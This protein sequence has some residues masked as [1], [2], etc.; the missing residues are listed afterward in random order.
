MRLVN[1]RVVAY[2]SALLIIF[3]MVAAPLAQAVA[4]GAS[5]AGCDHAG[6]IHPWHPDDGCAGGNDASH[7]T[8]SAHHHDRPGHQCHCVHS[9]SQTPAAGSLQLIAALPT[10]SEA[11]SGTLSGPAYSAPHFDFLRPPN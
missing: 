8:G 2:L 3:Q 1:R 11:I 10:E 5:A 7:P 9:V 6:T 4:G